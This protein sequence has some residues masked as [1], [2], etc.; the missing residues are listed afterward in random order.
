MRR[1]RWMVWLSSVLVISVLLCGLILPNMSHTVRAS[2][3]DVSIEENRCEN[4]TLHFKLRITG[5]E[6]CRSIKLTVVLSGDGIPATQVG[7]HGQQGFVAPTQESGLPGIDGLKSESANSIKFD[8]NNQEVLNGSQAMSFSVPVT[9]YVLV[10]SASINAKERKG[11]VTTDV[12]GD[13]MHNSAKLYFV[14][15]NGKSADLQFVSYTKKYDKEVNV[16]VNCDGN[17]MTVTVS[18]KDYSPLVKQKLDIVVKGKD[19]FIM[20][21]GRPSV[22]YF[23]IKPPT[24]TPTPTNTPTPTPIPTNTPTPTPTPK[25]TATP[26]TTNTPVPGATNT[27]TPVA[28]STPTPAPTST[29]VPETSATTETTTK[30]TKP[31]E[32]SESSSEETSETTMET[33]VPMES[34]ILTSETTE[35]ALVIV[36]SESE[37]TPSETSETKVTGTTKKKES[38]KQGGDFSW[39]ILAIV[40]LLLAAGGGG[41]YF[42][43]FKKKKKEEK[44]VLAEQPVVMNGYLQKPTVGVAAARAVRPIRSN[45]ATKT[46]KPASDLPEMMKNQQELERKMAELASEMQRMLKLDEVSGSVEPT[47]EPPEGSIEA[48][49]NDSMK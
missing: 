8:V 39:N 14:N 17:N 34:M 11:T 48:D 37:T 7:P 16:S 5:G 45:V 23:D 27:P 19:E 13:G 9:S 4:G 2:D 47:S 49:P 36:P 25:P 35:E 32:T 38:K 43:G 6:Y 26:A 20:S 18:T 24:P 29:P 31:S 22:E 33:L 12:F 3:P 1:S 41:F 10:D 30:A 21:K 42:F 46:V 44:P 15:T 28:T 40:L